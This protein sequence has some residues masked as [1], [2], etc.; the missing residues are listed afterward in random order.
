MILTHALTPVADYTCRIIVLIE[1]QSNPQDKIKD[2]PQGVC[3][4]GEILEA[5]TE[6]DLKSQTMCFSN[7][8]P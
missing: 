3:N 8:L 5:I 6:R 7:F 1:K 4:K 2:F